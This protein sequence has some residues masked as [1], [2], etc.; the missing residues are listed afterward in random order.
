MHVKTVAHLEIRSTPPS[1]C[2][3]F[4]L[5][6]EGVGDTG[7]REKRG[8]CLFFYIFCL[9]LLLSLS[10]SLSL[11]S[12]STAGFYLQVLMKSNYSTRRLLTNMQ[13]DGK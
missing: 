9:S 7:Q 5:F 1:L 11:L 4:R 3:A 12:H 13:D 8:N 2:V 6:F 10:L